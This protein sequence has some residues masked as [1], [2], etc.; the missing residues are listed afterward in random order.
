MARSHSLLLSAGALPDCVQDD[1]CALFQ[2]WHSRTPRRYLLELS[3]SASQFLLGLRARD[4]DGLLRGRPR[5]IN[6][7]RAMARYCGKH[8]ENGVS[9]SLGRYI[10]ASPRQSQAAKKPPRVVTKEHAPDRIAEHLRDSLFCPALCRSH[11]GLLRS[12]AT[13]DGR[14]SIRRFEHRERPLRSRG[15]SGW[16]TWLIDYT[17]S[18]P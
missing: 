9:A 3:F 8:D 4:N 5:S 12:Q 16:N 13:M 11:L 6:W 18:P 1:K 14:W 17:A 2:S 10:C 7:L 15:G